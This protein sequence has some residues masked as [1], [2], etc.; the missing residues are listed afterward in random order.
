MSL[1]TASPVK[2]W[3]CALQGELTVDLPF[4]SSHPTQYL[5]H[6]MVVLYRVHYGFLDC[7]NCLAILET[8]RG[9]MNKTFH[10]RMR[11]GNV[12]NLH[13][14]AFPSISKL[15]FSQLISESSPSITPCEIF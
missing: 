15:V 3:R 13:I 8:L 1:I 11:A 7:C 14:T 6:E 12:K 9:K 4:S 10:Y 2:L 5:D